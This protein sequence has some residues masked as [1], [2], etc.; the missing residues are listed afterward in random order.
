MR[1]RAEEKM[2]AP[3]YILLG[4]LNMDLDNPKNDRQKTESYIGDLKQQAFNDRHSKRIYFPFIGDHPRTNE[5][6]RTN[7][8][9][10]QTFDQIGFFLGRKEKRL[11]MLGSADNMG[12]DGPD[13]FDYDVF[14]FAELF[15]QAI[16]SKPYQ[17]LPKKKKDEFSLKF[18]DSVSDH[19]P[20]W[21]RIPRP[22]F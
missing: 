5:I 9:H 10:S 19:M 6:V 16:E 12:K 17:P 11:P 18:I 13:G 14:D 4:D 22:G 21:V 7:A 20:I 2:V 8:R 3:N 15:A 1:L